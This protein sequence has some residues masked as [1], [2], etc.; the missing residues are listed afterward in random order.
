MTSGAQGL[1][2]VGRWLLAG[3]AVLALAGCDIWPKP[4]PLPMVEG[5]EWCYNSLGHVA[6]CYDQPDVRA[7]GET[8]LGAYPP[9]PGA[10]STPDPAGVPVKPVTP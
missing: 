5:P 4:K 1:R 8:F 7:S 9:R 6:D 2:P 10:A 3:C